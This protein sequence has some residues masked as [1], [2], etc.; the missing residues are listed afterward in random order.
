MNAN[1]ETEVL[2][3]HRQAQTSNGRKKVLYEDKHSGYGVYICSCKTDSNEGSV[4]VRG[5]DIPALSGCWLKGYGKWTTDP[6]TKRRSFSAFYTE[7]MMPTTKT[8]VISFLQSTHSGLGAARAQALY[9]K[10]EEKIWDVLRDTPERLKEVNGITSNHIKRLTRAIEEMNIKRELMKMFSGSEEFN[11]HRAAQIAHR[12]NQKTLHTVRKNPYALCRLAQISFHTVDCMACTLDGISATMDHRVSTA[13]YY[14]LKE[15]ETRGHVCLPYNELVT[16]TVRTLNSSAFKSYV[17]TTQVQ[18]NLNELIKRHLMKKC[19]DMVYTPENFEDQETIISNVTRLLFAPVKDASYAHLMAEDVIN[20]YMR[21]NDIVLAKKQKDAVIS[22]FIRPISIVTGGPGTGKTTMTK[23]LLA[24]DKKLNGKNSNP[25][26]LAPTGRA[27]RR[28]KE[29]TN[30]E[31]QTVHSAINFRGDE[32][33][34][35]V[36]SEVELEASLIIVDEVSMLDQKIAA[37]FLA[38]VKSG[39]R[40][41]LVG[42]SDQLPSVGAGNILADLIHSGMIT[43]TRLDIIYRQHGTDNPIVS[44]A[45]KIMD[46][47]TDLIFNG[48]FRKIECTKPEAQIYHAMRAYVACVKKFG[49]DN[50]ILLNPFRKGKSS[51]ITTVEFNRQLQ[52]NLNSIKDTD[53]RIISRGEVF[54]KGDRVM[55]LENTDKVQNGDVGTICS[56]FEEK[57]PDDSK[58]TLVSLIVDFGGVQVKYNKENITELTLAYACT[59]HKSQGS[60]YKA[61]VMVLS[62]EHELM[63]QRNLFYTGITRASEIVIL[64]GSIAGP[65]SA[66]AHAI[67]TAT[68]ATRYSQLTELL[69]ARINK[70]KE[71]RKQCI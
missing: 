4:I 40:I 63:L 36:K 19:G 66:M 58:N 53:P 25:L 71:C 43:V 6:K 54:H 7:I 60:E 30:H 22:A 33:G 15:S 10:F 49:I 8:G 69:V 24:M 38:S 11:S 64:V 31:T 23:A 68:A 1:T 67:H 37:K 56:V 12:L 3:F 20:E 27:A 51:S 21:E 50:V 32:N 57:D 42:D 34:F 70:E 26:L 62:K 52:H 45:K 5:Y 17:A 16:A 46:D 14:T 2:V 65:N 41:V 55:Q 13:L 61:V 29:A 28:L 59:I 35:P 18:N 48:R 47:N 44:N 9:M 39:S